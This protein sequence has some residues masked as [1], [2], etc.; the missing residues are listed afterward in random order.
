MMQSASRLH[1]IRLLIN[2]KQLVESELAEETKLLGEDLLQSH[3]FHNKFH[4]T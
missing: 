3:F 4:M 1:G 2:V